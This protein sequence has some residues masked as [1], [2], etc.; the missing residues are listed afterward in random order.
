MSSANATMLHKAMIRELFGAALFLGISVLAVRNFAP[1]PPL[2]EEGRAMLGRPP[3]QEMLAAALIVYSFSAI[4]HILARMTSGS[5]KA[6]PFAH[7]GYLTAFYLFFHLSGIL[8]ENFWAVFAAGV[9]IFALETYQ[10]RNADG[11]DDDQ[12]NH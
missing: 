6:G 12:E 4:V 9:T 2:S 1:F 10:I 5:P 11:E 7:A 8:P 3:S